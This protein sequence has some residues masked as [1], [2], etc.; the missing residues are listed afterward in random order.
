M[1]DAL[2]GRNP[3]AV[4]RPIARVLRQADRTADAL[5]AANEARAILH[6]AHSRAGSSSNCS[7]LRWLIASLRRP[8]DPR[9]I[10]V[11]LR[12][13]SRVGGHH[14]HLARSEV[15]AC[16]KLLAHTKGHRALT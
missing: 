16:S 2:V 10:R 6:P 15:G 9:Q 4:D 5:N 7:P 1:S 13:C 8:H 12:A 3:D 11:R 14:A